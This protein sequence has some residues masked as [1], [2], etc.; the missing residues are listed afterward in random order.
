MELDHLRN[1]D[2]ILAG[3]NLLIG[4]GLKVIWDSL[5]ELKTTDIRLTEKVSSIEV[6]IA[7]QYVKRAELAEEL[8]DINESLQ[9]IFDKLDAKADK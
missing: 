5:R 3:L 6:L 1:I 8:R 4:W 7:G 9:R 2:G